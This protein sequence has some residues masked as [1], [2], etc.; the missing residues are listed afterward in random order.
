MVCL[1][2]YI[3]R[4]VCVCLRTDMQTQNYTHRDHVNWWRKRVEGLG[5]VH[6]GDRWD[7]QVSLGPWPTDG[8][9]RPARKME[10]I[11]I[12]L[13]LYMLTYNSILY[14]LY[15]Y[16]MYIY[17]YISLNISC[18]MMLMCMYICD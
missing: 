7:H 2:I 10:G 13:Q 9:R 6:H 15:I 12:E 8:F 4:Y 14:I 5:L 18:L 3:Y 11:K 17:I 1:C 16:Y